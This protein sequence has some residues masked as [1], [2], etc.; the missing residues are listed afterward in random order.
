MHFWLLMTYVQAKVYCM[1]ESKTHKKYHGEAK[2]KQEI[3]KSQFE[4]IFG[5]KSQCGKARELGQSHDFYLK[6]KKKTL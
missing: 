2:C 3:T 1:A 5:Q 4:R 6:R